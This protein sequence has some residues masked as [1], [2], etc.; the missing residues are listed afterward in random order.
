MFKKG[1]A[2]IE[3]NSENLKANIAQFERIL[4][5]GCKIM[6]AVKANAYGH[7]VVKICDILLKSDV[8]NFCVATLSE[9]IE[10]RQAG[11]DG[12]IL[13]MGY[14]HPE[15]FVELVRYGLTQSVVDARYGRQMGQFGHKMQVHIDIDTG[16]HRLGE[17]FERFDEIL[18]MWNQ[19]YLDITG[20]YSHLCVADS[21]RISDREYT[22]H[23][24]ANFSNVVK[25]LKAAGADGFKSHILS[26]YG[27]LNYP[28]YCFDYVRLGIALYG[29]LSSEKDTTKLKMDLRPV[30]T[31]KTR[32]QSILELEKGESVGYGLTYTADSPRRIAALSIGYADGISRCMSNTGYVLINGRK[33]PVVGRICMDQMTVDAT[34]VPDAVPGGEAVLLGKSGEEEISAPMIATWTGTITNEVLSRLGSRLERLTVPT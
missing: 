21:H 6:A 2:W 3:L 32:I 15:Q 25:R 11:I 22:L 9:G 29:I 27:V 28:K 5:K 23:Q 12:Q 14:T 13:V 19:E 17:R 34:D 10:L 33:A 7:G 8:R 20:V 16:M 30:L 26:S 31:L 4:P 18:S 24:I 1:R